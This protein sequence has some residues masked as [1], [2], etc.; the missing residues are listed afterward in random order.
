[1]NEDYIVLG[2]QEV[3][4]KSLVGL[5][6]RKT[7]VGDKVY[8]GEILTTGALDVMEYK[9]IVGEIHAQRYINTEDKRDDAGKGLELND[10]HI[11]VVVKQLFS[12]V[13]VEDG[14]DSS[15]IP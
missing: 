13:F 15:F 12:K 3:Y 8:K 14:G 1:M 11:E 7:K 4:T 6:P 2:V 5:A 10:K 9:K